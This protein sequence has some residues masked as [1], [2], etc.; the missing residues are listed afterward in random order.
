MQST[1]SGAR[2]P[3]AAA[4]SWMSRS[5]T[6][7]LD[8]PCGLTSTID[9]PGTTCGFVCCVC[10]GQ[11]GEEESAVNGGWHETRGRLAGRRLRSVGEG[12]AGGRRGAVRS[13]GWCRPSSAAGAHVDQAALLDHTLQPAPKPLHPAPRWARWT[14]RPPGGPAAPWPAGQKQLW[15]RRGISMQANSHTAWHCQHSAAARQVASQR[16]PC[17]LHGKRWL[18]R[19][20]R[21]PACP[22]SLRCA[23]AARLPGPKVGVCVAVV[24]HQRALLGLD[25][26]AVGGLGVELRAGE[27]EELVEVS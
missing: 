9:W 22:P 1:K 25:E 16:R 23:A 17:A 20:P 6:R 24:P 5:V 8:T 26:R 14:A 21:P 10:G 13:G 3:P 15:R 7:P 2:P 19:R 18:R 11:R 4:A 12:A 27:Q